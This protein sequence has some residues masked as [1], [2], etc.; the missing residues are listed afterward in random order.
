MK[1]YLVFYIILFKLIY[2]NILIEKSIII[3]FKG[4]I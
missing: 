4:D 1:K 2:N 3:K